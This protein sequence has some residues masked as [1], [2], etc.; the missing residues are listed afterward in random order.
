MAKEPR[1]RYQ[2][3]RDLGADLNLWLRG[4][5]I[6]ARPAT[7]L[8][9]VWRSCRR[10]PQVAGLALAFVLVVTAGVSGITWKWAEAVSERRR[11]ELE[12]DRALRNFRQAREAVDSLL[13]TVSENAALKAQN[14]EPLRREL[15]RTARDFYSKSGAAGPGP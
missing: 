11:T 1:E 2:T 10:R 7:R 14:L 12:R 3:A 13:T 8:E 4:E 5:P 6:K 9:R 15:L